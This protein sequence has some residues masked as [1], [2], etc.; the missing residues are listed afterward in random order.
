M[1][2]SA[3]SFTLRSGEF[4]VDFDRGYLGYGRG[5]SLSVERFSHFVEWSDVPSVVWLRSWCR[6][7][8]LSIKK[9]L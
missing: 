3:V 8:L 5:D 9:V 7:F 2:L 6:A 4:V 1:D